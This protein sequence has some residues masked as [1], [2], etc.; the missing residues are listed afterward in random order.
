MPLAKRQQMQPRTFAIGIDIMGLA[1]FIRSNED[2]II[3]GWED[4]ARTYLPSAEGLDRAALRDHIIGLL[5]FIADDLET[6]ETERERS[7]KAKGQGPEGGGK[8]G[9]AASTHADLRFE[10]GFDTIEMI[11][12]FRALRAS[13]IKLW[14]GEWSKIDDV[15]PDLLRFNEAIDQIM[16]ESLYRFVDKLNNSGTQIIGTIVNNVRDPLLAT[17]VSARL[18][19]ENNKLSAEDTE[20]VSQI[21]ATISRID[22]SLSEVI[23]AVRNPL[24]GDGSSSSD[25][26]NV[27]IAVQKDAKEIQPDHLKKIK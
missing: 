27:G 17:G 4:F 6:P 11:A 23:D 12:E 10:A 20:V 19:M 15:L 16:T 26:A 14:R 5:R 7:E 24:G 8:H 9:V 18:L 13:V 25:P 22:V 2:A 3:A 1:E 21:I